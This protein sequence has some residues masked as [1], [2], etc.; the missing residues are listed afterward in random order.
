MAVLGAPLGVSSIS[1]GTSGDLVYQLCTYNKPVSFSYQANIA[2]WDS[3]GLTDKFKSNGK[4]QKSVSFKMTFQLLTPQDG[5]KGL[6]TFSAGTVFNLKSYKLQIKKD[7]IKSSF[8]NSVEWMN[9]SAGLV[10]ISGSWTG[11]TDDTTAGIVPGSPIATSGGSTA[12]F[13]ILSGAGGKQIVSKIESTQRSEDIDP[14][15]EAEYTYSFIGGG[16]AITT[17]GT[18][19]AALW[20]A[21][22]D[23]SRISAKEAS[24]TLTLT[25]TSGVALSGYAVWESVDIEAVPNKGI[26]IT[27]SGWFDGTVTGLTA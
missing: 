27:V 3:T 5:Y 14:S 21:D 6:V 24:K 9:H 1:W 17:T 22:T 16:G 2:T 18:S 4:G 20:A 8:N 25:T 19:V 10:S 13:Q 15:K 7:I 23:G 26:T 11:S 12:T